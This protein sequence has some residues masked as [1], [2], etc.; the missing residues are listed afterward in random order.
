MDSTLKTLS[1]I[2]TP[3][4][5]K[6][7]LE[8]LAA[9]Y[10]EGLNPSALASAYRKI[11]KLAVQISK[12]YY[13]FSSEDLASFV[14]EELDK[15]LQMYTPERSAFSTFFATMLNNRLRMESQAL[16]T[17]KRKAFLYADSFEQAIENGYDAVCDMYEGIQETLESLKAFGL[18][19]RELTYCKL[20]MC[21]YKNS[22]I[23]N[24]LG[25]S[26]MTLSN[27][28]KVLRIKLAPLHLHSY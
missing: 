26:V 5:D 10:A 8:Q 24:M 2:I 15:S 9:V 22:E 11:F 20:V 14:L 4:L 7:S 25:V 17:D 27:M 6:L 13:G 18:T 28:R 19:L 16:S 1:T 21:D 12:K 23:A 3:E